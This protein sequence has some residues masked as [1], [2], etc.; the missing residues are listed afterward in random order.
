MV[1]RRLPRSLLVVF[2]A[3][4]VWLVG[5][6]TSAI[7]PSHPGSEAL[8]GD[9]ACDGVQTLAAAL[10]F[11]AAF[12]SRDRARYA[13]ALIAA[14]IVVWTL[15]DAYWVAVLSPESLPP[16]PSPADA[17]YL[18]FPPLV[19]AGLVMLLQTQI[20]NVPRTVV[21]DG[22]IVALAAATISAAF[23]I[24]PVAGNATGGTLE[25]ATNLAY[26]ITDLMLITVILTA[27]ALRGW[28]V[29]WTWGL[30]GAGSL[31]FFVA[32]SVYLITSA[33]GT[34]SSPSVFDVGW[35]GSAV[36][37]AAAAWA[38]AQSSSRAARPEARSILLPIAL[39]FAAII[40]ALLQPSDPGHFATVALGAACVTAVMVRLN[41]TFRENLKIIEASREEALTDALTGLRNRRALVA[42]L[43]R[44]IA[45]AHDG[46]PL[47]LALFD[48]D[49]FKHTHDRFG[50]PAG[51]AL[52]AR[53]GRNLDRCLTGRGTAYRVGGD[54]FCAIIDPDGEVAQ[55]ILE[56]A[57]RALSERG[58]GFSIGASYGSVTLPRE[59]KLPAE[60]LQ[61]ADQRMY[62]AKNS[63]REWAGIQITEALWRTLY[64][65]DATLGSHV[66]DVADLAAQVAGRLALDR[67]Q[68]DHVRSAAKLHDIGK[69]AIPDAI[70]GKPGPLDEREWQFVRNHTLI[71]ERIIAAAPS[72]EG[73]GPLVRSSH[74]H[75]DGSGYPDGLSGTEIP[76]GARI[77]AICDAFDAMLTDRSYRPAR[78]PDTALAEL[79]RCAG[80]QFD[81][82][83]VE[84]FCAE[85]EARSLRAREATAIRT[86]GVSGR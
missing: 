52:L 25:V 39:A 24:Q 83:V 34:Y 49:G 78:D 69:V 11:A 85:W 22:V 35:Y 71:G 67:R 21:A 72:L 19:L 36:V 82:V 54:E 1:S 2:G 53:L 56:M 4:G 50:H 26:P 44:Q 6:E 55:P 64:E 84:A 68:I 51:D 41:M 70:L 73:V 65:R 80:S 46:A 14:G 60:A 32:D 20:S 31:A 7:L 47:V 76:L 30:L 63:G 79:R 15:G 16:I 62:A 23:V 13:W 17:G 48:L 57:A 77:V 12:R 5:L 29:D 66:E 37:F 86:D 75:F 58:E 81:P 74:E 45:S 40:V 43:D 38:P 9:W 59:A 8:F 42:D 61:L 28:R 27:I 33:N 3:L 18:L 10:C